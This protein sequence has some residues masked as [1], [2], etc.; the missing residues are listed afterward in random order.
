[1]DSLCTALKLYLKFSFFSHLSGDVQQGLQNTNTVPPWREG[2][3]TL[4]YT[5]M[6]TYWYGNTILYIP[7]TGSILI[8]G[9]NT[10]SSGFEL[11]AW[12][13]CPH[14]QAS[15]RG[16]LGQARESPYLIIPELSV[17]GRWGKLSWFRPFLVLRQLP[18]T[19]RLSNSDSIPAAMT[20]WRLMAITSLGSS[21]WVSLCGQGNHHWS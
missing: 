12:G 17:V 16:Q 19:K 6:H 14:P 18:V 7:T 21:L 11:P 1:M 5:C 10:Q 9:K 3:E 8:Q 20:T 4:P 2:R 15:R 13:F